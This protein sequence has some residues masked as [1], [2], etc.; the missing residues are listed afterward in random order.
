MDALMPVFRSFELPVN[1]PPYFLDDIQ[2]L[3]IRAQTRTCSLA[4]LRQYLHTDW[5]STSLKLESPLRHPITKLD[6]MIKISRQCLSISVE[7]K[8]F[9]V[10]AGGQLGMSLQR[11][12]KPDLSG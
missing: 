3:D 6:G 9:G 8:G 7:L 12:G 10:L 5:C 1:Y 4:T 2:L 11:T